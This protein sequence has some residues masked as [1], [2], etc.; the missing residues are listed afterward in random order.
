MRKREDDSE[1]EWIS[2]E[3]AEKLGIDE[4]S[5]RV[6][7]LAAKQPV[8]IEMTREQMETLRKQWEDL[9]NG[10]PAEITFEVEGRVASKLRVAAYGYFSDTCCA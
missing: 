6:K 7:E 3:Q 4:G 10:H 8:R 1:P 2:P 9:E 5:K